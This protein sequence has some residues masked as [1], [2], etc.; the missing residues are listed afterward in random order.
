MAS[1]AGSRLL[2]PA[3]SRVNCL[4]SFPPGTNPIESAQTPYVISG[5]STPFV[6][7]H[8]ISVFVRSTRE[9][10]PLHP[11][12]AWMLCFLF[13]FRVFFPVFGLLLVSAATKP[14]SYLHLRASYRIISYLTDSCVHTEISVGHWPRRGRCV[15]CDREN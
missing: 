11:L 15:R 8:W 2:S 12:S 9:G 6:G 3:L 1:C 13:L 7:E 4:T 5:R 10:S 14:V